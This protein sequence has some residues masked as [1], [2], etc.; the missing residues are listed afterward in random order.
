MDLHSNIFKLILRIQVLHRFQLP[1]LHSNIFKLIQI[2]HLLKLYQSIHLHSN[3]F[4]L[5][6]NK[7]V[8]SKVMREFTF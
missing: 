5:I 3:I 8:D 2:P 7:N 1:Y 6:L 4:K